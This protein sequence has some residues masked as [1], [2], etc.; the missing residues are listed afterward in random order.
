[1]LAGPFRLWQNNAYKGFS[2]APG[3]D[4]GVQQVASDVTFMH[5][6]FSAKAHGHRKPV[7]GTLTEARTIV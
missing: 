1:M 4:E 3:P 2:K 7:S 5:R 6:H